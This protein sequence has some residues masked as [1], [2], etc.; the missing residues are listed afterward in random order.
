V[1]GGCWGCRNI[2]GPEEEQVRR[3]VGHRDTATEKQE[4]LQMRRHRATRHNIHEKSNLKMRYQ[5]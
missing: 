2:T 1:L 3:G 4:T 5:E